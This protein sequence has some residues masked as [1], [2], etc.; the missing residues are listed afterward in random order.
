VAKQS[1]LASRFLLAGYDISGDV[2][3]VDTIAGTVAL[4]DVTDIT[5]SAHSRIGGLRDG[6]MSITSWFDSGN[7]TPVLDA[8]PTSDVIASFLV[9]TSLGNPVACVNAKQV[10]YDPNRAADGALS[11][12]TECQANGYGLEW[13]V[14]LTPGVQTDTEA[15][16][17]T[18]V[19]NGAS[20]DYGAQAYL[21][22]TALTGTGAT[23]TVQ[24]SADNSTWSDLISF[25]EVEAAPA[26]QRAT[27]SNT[28]TVD[29]YLRVISAGTFS[30]VSYFVAF[31]RN[32]VAGVSF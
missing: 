9:Q 19:D 24:H 5:Q 12:K 8:L 4:L 26:Q 13:G 20:T 3:A 27:V 21:H 7:A 25:T 22:V 16:D 29:R 18:D 6:S 14:Q 31:M 10:N 11:L 23:I 17:G 15:S 1:G 28:T 30:S 32:L 2:S